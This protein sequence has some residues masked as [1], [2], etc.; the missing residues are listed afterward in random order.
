M[1]ERLACPVCSERQASV[2]LVR[3]Q[4][5]AHQNLLFTTQEGARQ[6]ARGDLRLAVCDACGFIFNVSFDY[7]K[8]EYHGAYENDQTC[9]P[10]FRE[11]VDSLV[12]QLVDGSG[13]RDCFIV[14]VGSG[15]GYFL[16]RLISYAGG[17]TRGIGFD[18]TH[19]GPESELDGDL[20][21]VR[22]RYDAAAATISADVVLCRYVLEHLPNARELVALIGEVLAGSTPKGRIFFETPSVD[23]ILR[24]EVIW[25]LYYEHCALFSAGSLTTLFERGGFRVDAIDERFGGQYLCLLGTHAP[26]TPVTRRPGGTP[27]LARRFA[28]REREELDRWRTNVDAL[29]AEGPIALWGAGAKGTTLANLIDPRCERIDCLIDVNPR[30]QGTFVGGSGHPI[31]GVHALA[32]RGIRT[33]VMMNPNYRD[34]SEQLLREAG[35]DVRLVS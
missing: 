12:E 6:A 28:E 27:A 34:E 16:R 10:A 19:D 17:T 33:A 23:W 29:A 26:D 14:E 13:I 20:R 22:A 31:V 30:K 32:R 2:F 7:G 3:E 8:L 35:L 1:S 25:D 9:S 18:P 11:H 4:V 15:S 5:P 21:F 24:N